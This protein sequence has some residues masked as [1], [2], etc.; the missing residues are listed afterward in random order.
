LVC[1]E[2]ETRNNWCQGLKLYLQ[3]AKFKD[4]ATLYEEAKS[5]YQSKVVEE[6]KQEITQKHK[7]KKQ[8]Y[9]QKY[10]LE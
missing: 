6:Q 7:D 5:Q 8:A 1:N 10:G 3:V 4:P 9:K 2:A